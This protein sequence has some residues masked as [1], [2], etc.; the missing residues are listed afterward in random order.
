MQTISCA[1]AL[2]AT[3]PSQTKCPGSIAQHGLRSGVAG[4]SEMKRCKICREEK[5]ANAFPGGR[6]LKCNSCRRIEESPN[7][8]RPPE[9]FRRCPKCQEN[10][11]KTLE[12]W[13][14]RRRNGREDLMPYCKPCTQVRKSSKHPDYEKNLA[15][16]RAKRKANPEAAR[17]AAKKCRDRK[18]DLYLSYIHNR[19]ARRLSAPGSFDST[20]VQ[21]KLKL[22]DNRCYYCNR[23]LEK[24]HIEHKIPLVRG[25]TNWPANICAACPSCNHRKASRTP[26]EF[27]ERLAKSPLAHMHV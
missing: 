21:M 16:S 26:R 9:G 2:T 13:Y 12:F 27:R 24:Y 4:M 11:P 20:H 10:K 8:I 18:P 19:R 23:E 7:K 17:A 3:G 22:Q 25:G 6:G 14:V 5:P 1:P 15:R